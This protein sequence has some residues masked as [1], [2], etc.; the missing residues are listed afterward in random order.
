GAAQLYLLEEES[1]Y[2]GNR[3][4]VHAIARHLQDVKAELKESLTLME[5][6]GV[7]DLPLLLAGLKY[8]REWLPDTE[9]LDYLDPPAAGAPTRTEETTLLVRDTV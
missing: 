8:L 3:N 7:R 9:M 4:D 6:N 1:H 5:Q 2:G